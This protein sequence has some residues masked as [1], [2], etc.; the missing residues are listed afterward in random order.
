MNRSIVFSLVLI[1]LFLP[2]LAACTVPRTGT[3]V[4]EVEYTCDEETGECVTTSRLY[5][6][7][8][9]AP[10][11]TPIVYQS[12]TGRINMGETFDPYVLP[13]AEFTWS[14]LEGPG[15]V[16]FYDQHA[17]NVYVVMARPGRYIFEALIDNTGDLPDYRFE[18]VV[19]V[20]EVGGTPMPTITPNTTP[21]PTPGGQIESAAQMFGLDP[22]DPD[23]EWKLGLLRVAMPEKF[24]TPTP[25][26][27]KPWWRLW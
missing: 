13:G 22:N 14:L 1:F 4:V 7:P 19:D 25:E 8:T 9:P 5:S 18:F 17:R 10:T 6:T 3:G 24:I 20:L 21:N 2:V 12:T 23:L 16:A 15:S 11:G 27:T 26:P